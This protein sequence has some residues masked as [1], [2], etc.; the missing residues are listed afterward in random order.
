MGAEGPKEAKL[1]WIGRRTGLRFIVTETAADTSF[2]AA[3]MFK[4]FRRRLRTF[5]NVSG[6][7]LEP[8]R[9]WTRRW[10]YLN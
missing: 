6:S 4:Y 8:S 2:G 5:V 9:R 1:V 3:V 10:G 7:T